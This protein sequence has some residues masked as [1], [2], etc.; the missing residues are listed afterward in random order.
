MVTLFAGIRNMILQNWYHFQFIVKIARTGIGLRDTTYMV[1]VYILFRT[2]I[3]QPACRAAVV[4]PHGM[5]P[6]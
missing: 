1:L 4:N 6:H 3:R 5:T 2:A